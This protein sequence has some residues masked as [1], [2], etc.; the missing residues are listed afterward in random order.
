MA[1][2]LATLLRRGGVCLGILMLLFSVGGGG[3]LQVFQILAIPLS[4]ILV[5]TIMSPVLSSFA[6][7]PLGGIFHPG[8]HADRPC[9]SLGVIEARRIGGEYREALEDLEF[10]VM[11][12]PD[13]IE[14]WEMMIGIAARDLRDIELARDILGRGVAALRKQK[15]RDHLAR[16]YGMRVG[17]L[18][19]RESLS[20]GSRP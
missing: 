2:S 17:T 16:V 10:V 1:P 6:A 19:R 8:R 15:N 20:G 18:K 13:E 7:H 9:P 5:A 11:E 12:A 14:A 4:I 3:W